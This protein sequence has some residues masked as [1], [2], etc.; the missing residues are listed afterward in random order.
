MFVYVQKISKIGVIGIDV[1]LY[2]EMKYLGGRGI[3]RRKRKRRYGVFGIFL[4]YI[5]YN[6]KIGSV[7]MGW[8]WFVCVGVCVIVFVWWLEDSYGC[9]FFFF[10]FV[11]SFLCQVS[12]FIDCMVFLFLFFFWREGLGL[13]I[14]IQFIFY[15]M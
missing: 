1:F 9:W 10:Y 7:G 2:R 11:G 12:W 3:R 4:Q 14:F 5:K 15:K 8:Q 6:N 13:Q